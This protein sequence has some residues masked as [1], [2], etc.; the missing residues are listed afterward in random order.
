MNGLCEKWSGESECGLVYINMN[1]DIIK[2]GNLFTETLTLSGGLLCCATKQSAQVY[3][4]YN[5]YISRT[6]A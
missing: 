2:A 6:I 3:I 1:I 4:L 5:I